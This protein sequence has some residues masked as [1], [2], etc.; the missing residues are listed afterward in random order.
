MKELIRR[1]IFAA[2]YEIRHK[3]L[4]T[5]DPFRQQSML[6]AGV[7]T[8]VIFD[9]G[10][11]IGVIAEKYR[12]LFP[13]AKIYAFEPFPEVFNELKRRM[14]GN[15]QIIPCKLALGSAQ[16]KKFLRV[17]A[18]SATNSLLE[19]EESAALY[20]GT[21]LMDTITTV[22]VPV[23][24]IDEFCHDER[25]DTIDILKMDTQGTELEVLKGAAGMLCDGRIRVIYTEMLVAPSYKGQS[26]PHELMAF[27][28]GF[29]YELSGIYNLWGR[30]KGGL[31]QMD[32]IF[33]RAQT[34]TTRL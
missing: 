10:A 6:L 1:M 11:N 29:G 30:N 34:G 13:G 24:T 23:A 28:D 5:T 14:S 32:A 17:N 26:K 8:P 12:Y 7:E 2:G 25:V 21:G 3:S 31:L 15:Q 18:S 19:T 4:G 20:W 9:V 16:T 27:L 33:V 22:E